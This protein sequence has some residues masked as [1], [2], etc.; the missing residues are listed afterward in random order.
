MADGLCAGPREYFQRGEILLY[1]LRDLKFIIN[2]CVYLF[3]AVSQR[4]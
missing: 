2:E 4:R 1:L 3:F